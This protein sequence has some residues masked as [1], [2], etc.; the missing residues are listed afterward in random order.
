[1]LL[2]GGGTMIEMF[3]NIGEIVSVLFVFLPVV[4]V[5][6]VIARELIRRIRVLFFGV[7]TDSQMSAGN[8]F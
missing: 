1:M 4:A 8:G 2:E 6:A 5:I 7:E 3:S